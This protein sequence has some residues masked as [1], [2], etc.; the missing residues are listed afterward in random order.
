MGSYAIPSFLYCFNID[1][2]YEIS[3]CHSYKHTE[4]I[5]FIDSK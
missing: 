5:F 3:I 1:G 4:E 2:P